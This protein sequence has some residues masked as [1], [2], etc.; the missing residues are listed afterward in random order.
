[1]TLFTFSGLPAGPPSRRNWYK[2]LLDHH[3]CQ[4]SPVGFISFETFVYRSNYMKACRHGQIKA[5]YVEFIYR[6]A[7]QKHTPH[8]ERHS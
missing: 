1:M 8:T 6:Y 5:N 4:G 3:D 7:S 2:E